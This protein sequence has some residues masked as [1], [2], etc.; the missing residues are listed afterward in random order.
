MARQKKTQF[1]DPQTMGREQFA[2]NPTR[3]RLAQLRAFYVR[4]LTQLAANRYAW[5][6]LPDPQMERFM[7]MSLLRHGLVVFYH[8]DRV[9]N[10]Y[11]VARAGNI[12]PLNVYDNPTS[13]QVIGGSGEFMINE[14]LSAEDCVPVWANY[15]R[16]SEMPEIYLYAERLSELD[17]SIEIEIINSRQ[18]KFAVGPHD[19]RL[20]M[21]NLIRQIREG[22]ETVFGTEGMADLIAG[23]TTIDLEGHPAKLMNLLI[24]KGKVWNEVMTFMG[25]NNSNQDKKERLVADEVA[26]NDEQIDVM[27]ETGLETRRTACELINEKYGLDISV[28]FAQSADALLPAGL[29]QVMPQ[30]SQPARGLPSWQEKEDGGK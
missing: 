21:Q 17:R 5:E 24:S 11:I 2:N 13:F 25:I 4:K 23:I 14:T 15:L 29:E 16:T 27:K 30:G 22:Q 20:A 28:D 18:T 9:Y 26:A 10:D 8:E 12:G 1:Y 19:Q 7:E 6:G 3:N